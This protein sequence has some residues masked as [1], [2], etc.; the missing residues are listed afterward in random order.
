[1]LARKADELVI[2]V[3][4]VV[5]LERD[6]ASLDLPWKCG[7]GDDNENAER[8]NGKRGRQGK[9]CGGNYSKRQ[10]SLGRA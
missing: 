10:A 9:A 7:D 6:G 5:G 8:R 1:M 4:P 2:R 3:C